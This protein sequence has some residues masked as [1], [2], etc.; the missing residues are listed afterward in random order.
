MMTRASLRFPVRAGAAVVLIAIVLPP[1][2]RGCRRIMLYNACEARLRLV[3]HAIEYYGDNTG[4]IPP[5]LPEPSPFHGVEQWHCPAAPEGATGM[6]SYLYIYRPDTIHTLGKEPLA[7][8]AGEFGRGG[9][10]SSSAQT[11]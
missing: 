10:P 5:H 2:V 9:H 3:A 8:E 7:V 11:M 4:E 1:C 6:D